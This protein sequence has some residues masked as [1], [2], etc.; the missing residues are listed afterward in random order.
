MSAVC[1][2]QGWVGPV[3]KQQGHYPP[4]M[5][6]ARPPAAGP[7]Q[8]ESICTMDA[9]PFVLAI[10]NSEA[11]ACVSCQPDA[12]SKRLDFLVS[13]YHAVGALP[14]LSGRCYCGI[15]YY[16]APE[17][18]CQVDGSAAKRSASSVSIS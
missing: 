7:R 16:N 5:P 2:R 1:G 6:Q 11:I 8:L 14:R 10:S 4:T 17:Y 15:P 18:L 3:I 9:F 12:S 13:L